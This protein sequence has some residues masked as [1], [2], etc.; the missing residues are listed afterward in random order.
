MTKIEILNY[1]RSCIKEG[2]LREDD[3]LDSAVFYR[4]AGRFPDLSISRCVHVVEQ[5][6]TEIF[7]KREGQTR[8]DMQ[9]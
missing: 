1:L 8:G 7:K 4:L 3:F 9:I 5:L 6:R 2:S